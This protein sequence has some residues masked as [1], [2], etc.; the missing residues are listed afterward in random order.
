MDAH[1]SL[2]ANGYLFKAGLFEA[3]IIDSIRTSID[4][5][6]VVKQRLGACLEAKDAYS[7]SFDRSMNLWRLSPELFEVISSRKVIDLV[8]EALQC[9]A[10]RLSH[11]QCLYKLPKCPATP[12]HAD[13]FHWP[14]ESEKTI[15][16]WVPLQ[17]TRPTNGSLSFFRGSHLLEDKLREH[18]SR[19][20]QAEIES[21]FESSP[22]PLDEPKY[23][24]GDVSL[25]SGWTFHKASNN[26][27]DQIRKIYTITYMADGVTITKLRDEHQ[28]G[29]LAN[30][31]P[32]CAFGDQLDSPLNPRLT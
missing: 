18:L 31:C 8:R 9:E 14:I 21:Y 26:G 4:N 12:I 22:F 17:A 10:I 5:L 28:V 7:R 32:G 29:M 25:H 1:A 6:Q 13:Q 15:T 3:S 23:E 2:S 20:S 19:S 16:L 27:S 30:W 24:I 11:D